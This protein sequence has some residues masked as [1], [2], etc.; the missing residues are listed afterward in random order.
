MS[1]GEYSKLNDSSRPKKAAITKGEIKK[2]IKRLE[3]GALI[4]TLFIL[5]FII[6][7]FVVSA[8]TKGELRTGLIITFVVL[9]G[10][11]GGILR[12]FQLLIK[13]QKTYMIL[14]T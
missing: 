6:V 11:T 1:D 9:T 7:T 8:I 12:V 3:K 10:I 13:R 5:F 4:T 2:G 14:Y